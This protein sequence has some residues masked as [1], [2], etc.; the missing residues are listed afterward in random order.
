MMIERKNKFRMNDNWEVK[1]F[2]KK[3]DDITE[4]EIKFIEEVIAAPGEVS[5]TN[6][7]MSDKYKILSSFYLAKQID[8]SSNSNDKHSKAIRWLT[9]ALVIVGLSQAIAV[10]I[11]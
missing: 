7:S 5:H 2:T 6:F 10:C 9:V 1:M 4:E 8:A 3:F 11:K